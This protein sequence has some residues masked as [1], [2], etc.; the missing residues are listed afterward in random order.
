MKLDPGEPHETNLSTK[1]DQTGSRP[2]FS[3]QNENQGRPQSGNRAQSERAGAID[4][5]IPR[6][7]KFSFPPRFRLSKPAEYRYV[8]SEPVKSSDRYFTILA[9]V[10]GLGHPRLGLAVAKKNIKKAVE[11]SRIKRA[12]RESFR[13]NQHPLNSMDIVVLARRDAAG[14]DPKFIRNSLARHWV[15]LADQCASY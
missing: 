4:G 10:N 6:S 3:R 12:V 15:K 13:L 7:A 1:Q 5:I 8:F 11:R 14:A 2:R 9:R